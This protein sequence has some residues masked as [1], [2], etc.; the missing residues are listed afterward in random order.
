[1]NDDERRAFLSGVSDFALYEVFFDSG[2]MLIGLLDHL[3][4]MAEENHDEVLCRR[5]TEEI[6]RIHDDRLK[7]RSSDRANQIEYTVKW[8][9]RR[10]ELEKL[11]DT[12]VGEWVS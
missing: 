8:T 2:N 10:N 6:R 3:W 5:Y 12:P 7:V 1:M 11:D 4:T 9:R